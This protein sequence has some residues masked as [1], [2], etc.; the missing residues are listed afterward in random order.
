MSTYVIISRVLSTTG[1]ALAVQYNPPT[2][3]VPSPLTLAVYD[4]AKVAENQKWLVY[5]GDPNGSTVRPI[6]AVNKVAVPDKSFKLVVGDD[7]KAGVHEI[8]FTHKDVSSQ[9]KGTVIQ[10]NDTAKKGVWGATK[11]PSVNTQIIYGDDAKEVWQSWIFI[12][13]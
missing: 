9:P 1:Q 13:V 5:P 7:S 11:D 2:K 8:W 6:G 4:S 10:L 3:D 12:K